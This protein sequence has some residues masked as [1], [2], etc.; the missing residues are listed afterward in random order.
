M[1]DKNLMNHAAD[2]IRILASSM[3]EKAKSG[4]PGGAMG[5][6]TCSSRSSSFGTQKTRHGKDAT[7]SSLIQDT[8]RRCST[9]HWHSRASLPLTS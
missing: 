4:H 7:A 2:N 3:V 6:S 5:S 8:C 9:R 1:N